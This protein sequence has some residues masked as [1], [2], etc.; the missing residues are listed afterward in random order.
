MV[1]GSYIFDVLRVWKSNSQVQM[2]S[3]LVK[4][5]MGTTGQRRLKCTKILGFSEKCN[6]F[7]CAGEINVRDR[8]LK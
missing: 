2:K 6:L 8:L 7:L 1:L 5:V 3:N 4:S